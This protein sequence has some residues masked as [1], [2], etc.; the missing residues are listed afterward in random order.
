MRRFRIND[1][2]LT[3]LCAKGLN[4]VQISARL[5]VSANTVNYAI[6]RL[7]LSVAAAPQGKTNIYFASRA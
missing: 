7:N 2:R 1:S 3:E 6:K 5:G 4:V